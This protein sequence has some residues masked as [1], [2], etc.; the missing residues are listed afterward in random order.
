[1]SAN[2]TRLAPG[3]QD[4]VYRPD[5]DG[6]RAIAVLAVIFYHAEIFPFSGG[7]IGV[8]VFFVISGFLIT[9][10]IL[11]KLKTNQF[12]MAYFY[13]RRVRRIFPA[14]FT[15]LFVCAVFVFWFALP[16]D[17]IAFGESIIATALFISNHY[18]LANAGYFSDSAEN[19]PLL[20]TWSLAVEEQFY[21]LFPFYLLCVKRFFHA[22]YALCTA[23]LSVAS[24]GTGIWLIRINPDAG[25]YLA[26]VRIWEIGIGAILAMIPRQVE[27]ERGMR[28]LMGIIGA[29]LIIFATTTFSTET[30]FPGV[31]ALIPCLG[32]GLIIW[33]GMG[34]ANIV[35][36]ILQSRLLVGIGLIS[37]PLYLWHWP[38]L[39]F[40]KNSMPAV[41]DWL[42]VIIV[43]VA[44][45]GLSIFSYYYVERPVR[46]PGLLLRRRSVF[47]G[48]GLLICIS[49]AAGFSA[50]VLRDLP[51]QQYDTQ[52][53]NILA[54]DKDREANDWPCW[55]QSIFDLNDKNYCV[56]GDPDIK[57]LSF[58]LWGDSH[59]GTLAKAVSGFAASNHRAGRLAAKNGCPP[60]LGIVW[61]EE[62]VPVKCRNFND[63]VFERIVK[64]PLVTDVVLVARWAIYTG[65]MDIADT[66]SKEASEP[67]GQKAFARLFQKTIE[68]IRSHGKR[69]WILAPVPEVG[70]H[71]PNTLL[72]LQI[73]EKK[74]TIGL[75]K[76][77]HFD[78][79]QVIYQQ[80]DK[81]TGLSGVTVLYPH[82]VLCDPY[83]RCQVMRN[84]E[85]YYFDQHHLTW[86]GAD[87]LSPLFNQIFQTP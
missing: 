73:L 52:T 59:A 83:D 11:P 32:T 58:V 16:D 74:Q 14:L 55:D 41:T 23:I 28:N 76:D 56:L 34:A 18:F 53:L 35:S 42:Q 69:V 4:P 79:Q 24:F 48:A 81:V 22:R 7:F 45:L 78:R 19:V 26:S 87:Q 46:G 29:G 8:D 75:T 3:I 66:Q 40:A 33:S 49:L 31:N 6:L 1:M 15:M 37:Y 17:R 30:V 39:V 38:L 36:R 13:E 80:L 12:S 64:H 5:I 60:L 21:I 82:H 9:G 10:I 68:A 77:V 71:L 63:F 50:I 51:W 67:G 25:F 47:L 62:S 85:L 54:A 70:V 43:L 61:L 20:H 72:R 44:T 57:D 65:T 86:L 2:N 84:G 27:T